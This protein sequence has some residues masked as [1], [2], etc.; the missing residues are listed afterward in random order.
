MEEEVRLTEAQPE[1]VPSLDI[2]RRQAIESGF[3]DAYERDDFADLVARPD[4]KLREWIESDRVMVLVVKSELTPFCYGVFNPAS[5]DVMGLYAAEN[6]EGEGHATRILGRFEEVGRERE[7]PEL[8]VEA[9]RN[10]RGY[11]EHNGFQVRGRLESEETGLTL[12]EMAKPLN[13]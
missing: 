13:P 3:T 5:G 4:P 6:Y 1:D 9:P 7:L 11:F 2:V 8:T 10:A 12:L